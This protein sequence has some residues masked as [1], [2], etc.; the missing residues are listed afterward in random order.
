[1]SMAEEQPEING[2]P[3]I[4]EERHR[5]PLT[6]IRGSIHCTPTPAGSEVDR[7]MIDDLLNTLAE[8]AWAV[9]VRKL[10]KEKEEAA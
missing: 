8:I 7:M 4:T 1:M 3:E 5:D 10:A 2:L 6:S 9:A